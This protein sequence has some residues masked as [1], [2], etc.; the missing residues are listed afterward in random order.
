MPN[1][2]PRR[3]S[4]LLAACVLLAL[5]ALFWAP[6]IL[7]GNVPVPGDQQTWMLPWAAS[8]FPEKNVTQW[9][10]FW[11][12]GVAQF[13]PWRVQLHRWL[14]RGEWPL[15][16]PSQ[17]CGYPFVGNGQSAMFYPPNWLY[18]VLHPRIGFPVLAAVHFALASLLTFAYCRRIGLGAFPACY[19]GIAFGFG[20]FMVGLTPLPTLMNSAAWLPGC[21]LGVEMTLRDRPAGGVAVLGLC[22]GMTVLAGHLQ[23]AAYVLLATGLYALAR[24]SYEILRRRPAR[25]VGLAAGAVIGLGLAAAQ[26]LPSVELGMLSPRGGGTATAEVF[27]NFHLP[28]ALKPAELMTLALPDALGSPVRGDYRGMQYAQGAVYGERCGYVG[29]LT[30]VLGLVGLALG[31]RRWRW[32]FA[33]AAALALWAAMGGLPARVIYFGVP[34]VALTGG[35]VRLLCL[36]TFLAAVLGG[37]GLE[38]L[39]S[40]TDRGSASLRKMAHLVAPVALGILCLELFTW[41]WRTIPSAPG[42]RLYAATAATDY[43]REHWRPGDRVLAVTPRQSW[44]LYTRPNAVLP[45]NSATAYDGLEN[46]Q[47]YDS[48]FPVS[49]DRLAGLIE[50]GPRSPPENGNMVLLENVDSPLV[51]LAGVRWIVTGER[52]SASETPGSEVHRVN[53]LRI[54]RR[55]AFPRAFFADVPLP[56]PEGA[57]GRLCALRSVEAL[58]ARLEMSCNRLEVG[59]PEVTGSRKLIVT[60][61]F[62]PGWSAWRDGT[63]LPVSPVGGVFQGVD[64]PAS[65]ASRLLL[66]FVPSTVIVGLFVLLIAAGTIAGLLLFESWSARCSRALTQ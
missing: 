35:F 60:N 11:W 31:K 21:L 1:Q 2:P 8:E 63:R 42:D 66:A 56:N 24:A 55:A 25:V 65:G 46:I 62:Y 14:R 26:L 37:L 44:S 57:L 20:G 23:I 30:L 17:F 10:A 52:E 7:R 39:A 59:L 54:W 27:E 41:G 28:R 58:D 9:D 64:V 53:G 51:G 3:R 15:W 50:Q 29:I 6:W 5:V 40:V 45:P 47:G 16:N 61:T 38:A 18:G 34:K 43:L 4:D 13:Y 36:Y 22:A 19:A 33:V 12:D 49:F 32:G 48:L